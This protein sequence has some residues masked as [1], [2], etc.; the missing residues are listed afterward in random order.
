MAENARFQTSATPKKR[1]SRKAAAASEDSRPLD[2]ALQ[3]AAKSLKPTSKPRT[4]DD[5]MNNVGETFQQMLF[6]LIDEKGR[7]DVEVYKGA[8]KDKKLFYKIRSNV[9]Y[10]PTKHTV[11]AFALS[12]RLS[13]DETKDLL[14]T[15]G[16]AMSGSNRF[17]LIMRYVFEQ[18]I[19]DLYKID[20]ILYDFGEEH[21]F[22]CE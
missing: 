9:N 13:L 1:A 18:G 11:Y 15:A 17:D 12:L 5:L 3:L 6:R 14:Q 21:Y 10:Q 8:G 7:E 2:E 19:Y 20:C 16:Y 22:S 4:L